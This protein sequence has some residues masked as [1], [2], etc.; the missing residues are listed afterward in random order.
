VLVAQLFQNARQWKKAAQTKSV[1]AV[2]V[3]ACRN[4]ISICKLPKRLQ[5][6]NRCWYFCYFVTTKKRLASFFYR[7][8]CIHITF[9]K[10]IKVLTLQSHW[11]VGWSHWQTAQPFDG[12]QKMASHFKINAIIYYWRYLQWWPFWAQ[13]AQTTMQFVRF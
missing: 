8:Q 10:N 13:S 5:S 11:E 1:A 4:C 3:V 2:V 6:I 9:Y 7:L 12:L